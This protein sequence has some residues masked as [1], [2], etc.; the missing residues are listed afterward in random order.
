MSCLILS[1]LF[2]LYSLNSQFDIAR[3]K[4]LFE[5]CRCKFC[6]L[7]LSALKVKILT[8]AGSEKDVGSDKDSVGSKHS[9]A[10]DK[11]VKTDNGSQTTERR[12][13]L[14]PL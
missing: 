9:E 8:S 3:I 14:F 6:R 7:L 11:K 1:I 4:T 12:Y 2:A 10:G 13:G 5:I